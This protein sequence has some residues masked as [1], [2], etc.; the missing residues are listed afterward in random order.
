[1]P[2]SSRPVSYTH[3]EEGGREEPRHGELL[4]EARFPLL[5]GEREVVLFDAD[6][7][8][9]LRHD[10]LVHVGVLSQV[11]GREMEAERARRVY[12]RSQTPACDPGAAVGDER[13]AHDLEV[14]HEF[15]HA[16]V[17]GRACR[18]MARG[19]LLAEPLRSRG[20]SRVDADED[21]AIRLVAATLR[22]VGRGLRQVFELRRDARHPAR[23]REL[24][25]EL[26][27][28]VQVMIEREAGLL[29]DRVNED[30]PVD[31]RVPVAV[32]ADPAPDA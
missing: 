23:D 25:A 32:A 7:S 24:G 31:E 13:R 8:E 5:L 30:V 16:G 3:L 6:T 22:A 15:L 19:F 26:V 20:Q 27:N 14:G 29:A 18:R 17:R 1:M 10:A 4:Q 11:D 2:S 28:L 21:A 9:Q 12:E